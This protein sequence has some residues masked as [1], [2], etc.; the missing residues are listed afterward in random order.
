VELEVRD[1]WSVL[2]DRRRDDVL[3]RWVDRVGEGLRGRVSRAEVGHELGEIYTA[4]VD[5]VAAGGTDVRSELFAEVRALLTEL[6]GSKA[7][8]GFTPRETAIMMFGLRDALSPAI[9]AESCTRSDFLALTTFIDEL[10]LFTVDAYARARDAVIVEQNAQLLELSTPVIK[11]W[12]GI[13]AVPLVG[14][15]DSART[16]LVMEALLQALVETGSHHAIIDITGVAAVD[17]QVAQHLLKTVM[18]AQ[19]MGAECLVSGIRPQIA[20]TVASLGIEFGEIVTKA[21]LAD[22]LAL[23]LRRDGFQLHRADGRR[24]G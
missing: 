24:G 21:T 2:L 10:G 8:Q 15:L 6:S 1:R 16:Q 3:T 9:D 23:A 19:L 13:V 18:A 4:L 20:Q 14:M 11:I 7:R 5:A 17:T 22:A 12:E